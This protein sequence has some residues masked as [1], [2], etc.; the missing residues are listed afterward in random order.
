[1]DAN[2][3][4]EAEE[5]LL[6]AAQILKEQTVHVQTELTSLNCLNL[7]SVR[8]AQR[9]CDAETCEL[10]DRAI[11][12]ATRIGEDKAFIQGLAYTRK[13]WYYRCTGDV[14][15]AFNQ[16][17]QASKVAANNVQV[18]VEAARQISMCVSLLQK[19]GLDATEGNEARITSWIEK[20]I[21]VLSRARRIGFNNWAYLEKDP[22]FEPIRKHRNF[23][24]LVEEMKQSK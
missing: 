16:A 6:E 10:L 1:M 15:E 13:S 22:A 24:A 18:L 8:L 3:L 9:R 2:K 5:L 4:S 7:A 20:S 17:S 14:K 12:L 11:A 19:N 21:S 23:A